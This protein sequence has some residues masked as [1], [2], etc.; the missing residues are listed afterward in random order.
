MITTCYSF[1]GIKTF[2][3]SIHCQNAR[4][5]LV[6]LNK[7]KS[8]VMVMVVNVCELLLLKNTAECSANG[9]FI[10]FQM[11]LLNL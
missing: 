4:A 1:H 2:I 8:K 3:F 10:I 9:K 6:F 5:K 11:C 7:N